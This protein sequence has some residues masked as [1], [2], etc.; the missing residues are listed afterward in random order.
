MP[1]SFVASEKG[2]RKL[3]LGG[4][5]FFKD[6]QVGDKIYWKCERFQKF[7]CKARVTTVGD[8][9]IIRCHEHNHAAEPSMQSHVCASVVAPFVENG[10]REIPECGATSVSAGF[11]KT[12][13]R[14]S[15]W[16]ILFWEAGLEMGTLLSPGC[17]EISFLSD[18]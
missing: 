4:H 14:E 5:L 12:E 9:I 11:V 1:L 17:D 2:K 10:V 16:A 13:E 6:K 18:E 3:R 7:K 8:K 15:V